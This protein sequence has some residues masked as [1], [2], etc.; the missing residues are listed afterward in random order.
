MRL[1]PLCSML[2]Q[3]KRRRMSSVWRWRRSPPRLA[4][5]C[6]S[7]GPAARRAARARGRPRRASTTVSSKGRAA[8]ARAACAASVDDRAGCPRSAAPRA[9][10]SED[11]SRLQARRSIR[12]QRATVE[13]ARSVKLGFACACEF[14]HS[15]LFARVSLTIK[16]LQEARETTAHDGDCTRCQKSAAVAESTEPAA[17]DASTQA[18]GAM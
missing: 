2:P 3:Q 15:F 1:R 10:G 9:S 6:R 5:P 12:E 4:W 16:Q 18:R 14:A 11:S 17:S 7:A 13:S 8:A